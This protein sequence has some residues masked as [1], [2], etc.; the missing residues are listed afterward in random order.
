[1][2]VNRVKW[3]GHVLSREET[4]VIRLLKKIIVRKKERKSEKEVKDMMA[5]NISNEVS[6]CRKQS[7]S[8]SVEQG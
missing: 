6:A 2:R 3:L 7:L 4:E 1:M 5:S 8:V